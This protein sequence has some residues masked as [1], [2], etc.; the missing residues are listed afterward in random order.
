MVNFWVPIY[1]NIVKPGISGFVRL[2]LHWC[3]NTSY[4]IEKQCGCKFSEVLS[5]LNEVHIFG[6]AGK[7]SNHALLFIAGFPL[8]F[9]IVVLEL[10]LLKIRNSSATKA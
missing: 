8:T 2:P 3:T 10:L 7:G 5:E 1:E 6:Q 4:I 9:S